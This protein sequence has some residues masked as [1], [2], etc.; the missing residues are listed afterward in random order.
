MEIYCADC[1]SL[2]Q[3]TK[4]HFGNYYKCTKAECTGVH[5]AHPN[6]KPVGIPADR[7]TRRARIRAH[8]A[9]DRLWE[10][11]IMNRTE[12]YAW[13][14]TITGIT[15]EQAHISMLTKEQCDLVCVRVRE[16]FPQLF[17]LSDGIDYL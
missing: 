10:N 9:F 17:P 2:M 4:N 1:G 7:V 15:L 13:L 16:M 8:E 6:G 12:A 5:Q 11:K 14:S 3:L